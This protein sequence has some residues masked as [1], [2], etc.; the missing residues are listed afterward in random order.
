MTA[1][2][3]ALRVLSFL[4]R[5]QKFAAFEWLRKDLYPYSNQPLPHEIIPARPARPA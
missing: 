4:D 5:K 3:I 1:L 2:S